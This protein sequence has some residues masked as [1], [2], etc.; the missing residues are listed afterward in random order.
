MKQLTQAVFDGQ[1]G[2]YMSAAINE[3]G[4]ARLWTVPK[5]NIQP[6]GRE[7]IST[8]IQ[9]EVVF[10][11]PLGSGYDATDWQNSAIDREVSA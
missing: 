11:K 6:Y 2:R 4:Y 7:F 1:P 3:N 5:S 10:S 9:G 8:S